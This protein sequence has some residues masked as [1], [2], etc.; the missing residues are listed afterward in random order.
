MG[1]KQM[2]DDDKDRYGWADLME[3]CC[4]RFGWRKN[5]GTTNLTNRTNPKK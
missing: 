1:G 2:F 4:L 3:K 5:E